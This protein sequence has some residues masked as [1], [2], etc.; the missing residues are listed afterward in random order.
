MGGEGR[1]LEAEELSTAAN[2]PTHLLPL[3]LEFSSAGFV[4]LEASS[5][6]PFPTQWR[7]ACAVGVQFCV[8]CMGPEEPQ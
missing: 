2:L 1:W 7:L 5:W 4:L 6:L 8:R 3:A